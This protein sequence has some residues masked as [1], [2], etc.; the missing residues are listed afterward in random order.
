MEEIDYI[1]WWES[2]KEPELEEMKKIFIRDFTN[3]KFLPSIYYPILY[4]FFKNPQLKHYDKETFNFSLKK[5]EEI[6]NK[7]GDELMLSTLLSNFHLLISSYNSLID[8]EERIM[9]M[10]RFNSSEELKTKIFSINIYNDMLNTVFCD[11]L[12]LFIEFQSIIENNDKLFQKH[13]TAQIECLS[14]PTRGYQKITDLADSNIRNAM[15][16]GGVKISGSTVK[17]SYTIGGEYFIQESSTYELRDSM[18]QLFDGVSGI[19]LSWISYLCKKNITY[20]EVYENSLV[21]EETSLFFEKLSMSTLL[22]SCDKVFTQDISNDRGIKQQ[23]NVE[24]LGVDLDIDSRIMFGLCTAERIFQL[25]NLSLEDS[26]MISYHSPKTLN[27]FFIV[28]CITVNNLIS[29]RITY[30]EAYKTILSQN[31][32]MMWS[33]NEEE[34]NLYED[35]FRY[36]QDIENE[37]F[38]VTEIEDI[39]IEGKKRFKAVGYLKRAK[40]KKHVEKATK[41]IIEK[42]KKYENYGFSSHKVKHGKMDADIIYLVLYKK[43]VR[44]GEDRSLFP[45]NENFIVQIQYDVDNEFPIHNNFMYKQF[46]NRREKNI[47]YNW[48]PNF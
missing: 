5:I 43:E 7:L 46:K 11:N 44:R 1:N 18:L 14:K 9:L 30:E 40:R 25:R 6:E 3:V 42:I 38:Y 26:I 48:N 47:D 4:K 15:S 24:L 23:V 41:S 19:I 39:S 29:G 17:F 8:L 12:K 10:N 21:H 37:D 36:Y 45:N 33:V 16:H 31:Q 27:S 13:L 32:V 35:A 2:T 22:I 34:R 20:D 28:D